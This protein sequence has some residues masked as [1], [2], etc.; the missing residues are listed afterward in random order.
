MKLYYMCGKSNAMNFGD[1]LN[2][3]IW[4]RLI[5]EVF[6]DNED[7]IFIGIGTLLEQGIGDN[8]DIPS[9]NLING[10]PTARHIIIFGTGAG[11]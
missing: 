2:P 1:E 10:E 3:W 4:N 9:S 7:A 5:P 11:Y 8:L 6:D